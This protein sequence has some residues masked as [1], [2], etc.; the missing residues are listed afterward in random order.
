[1]L[2]NTRK[3]SKN[4]KRVKIIATILKIEIFSKTDLCRDVYGGLLMYQIWK[5]YLDLLGR[6]CKKIGLTYFQL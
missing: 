2:K 3:T 4:P 5:M 1:M 6:Y